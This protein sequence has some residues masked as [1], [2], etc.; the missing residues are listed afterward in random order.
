MGVNKNF[1]VKNG[2]EVDT[3]LILANAESNRVGIGTSLPTRLLHVN[4]A[5]GATHLSVSGI[6][7][8]QTLSLDGSIS[9]ANTYGK[10]NQIIIA[11]GIGGVSWKNLPE[12][13]VSESYVAAANQT[14]FV[15]AETVG[16]IDVY[17]NGV[18]L[19]TDNFVYT[20][21][22]QISLADGTFQGDIVEIIGYSAQTL[23][24]GAGGGLDGITVYQNGTIKGAIGLVTAIDFID[25]II[26]VNSTG[27]A[28]TV[29]G[30]GGG[31]IWKETAT[32]LSTITSV[33][34]GTTNA[35]SRLTVVG[36]GSFTEGL[37]VSGIT[38]LGFTTVGTSST[39]LSLYVDGGTTVS[40]VVTAG[41]FEGDGS[42]ITG[43][44]AS[45]VDTGWDIS[46]VG[47]GTTASVGIGTTNP[48]AQLQVGRAG[49]NLSSDNL[50]VYGGANITGDV[51]IGSSVRASFGTL[52]S[53]TFELSTIDVDASS[54]GLISIGG[55]AVRIIGD[56]YVDGTQNISNT[57]N[58]EVTDKVVG[59]ASTS[60]ANDIS[61]DGGG[62]ILY[63]DSNKEFLWD[64]GNNAW[65]SNVNIDLQSNRTYHVGGEPRLSYGQL[66]VPNADI[67]GIVTTGSLFS[68]G[69]I[70]SNGNITASTFFGSGN[71]LTG[72]VT[73]IVAGSNITISNSTG[74]VIINAIGVGTTGGGG[75]VGGASVTISDTPPADP[76]SGDLWY[77]S[78]IGRAFIW[79]VDA[80]TSQWVDLSPNGGTPSNSITVEN[81]GT[82]L[83]QAISTINFTG[84]VSISTSITGIATVGVNTEVI[85]TYTEVA[86]IATYAA[87]AGIATYS[88]TAGIAT[89]AAT[90]GI[91]TYAST[92][93]IAS[94][95]DV[96]GISSYTVLS[97]LSTYAA[98]SGIATYA[99]TAGVATVS[100]GLTG[101]PN[102]VV[103]ILTA[104]SFIGDG[105]GLTGVTAEGTGIVVKDSGSIVGTAGTIDFGD[106][107]SLSPVVSGV[108]TVTASGGGSGIST[109]AD[110]AG[111]STYSISAGIAT[112]SA[113]AGVSSALQTARN[114]GGVS[115]DGSADINL[116]GVNINGNQN[117]SGTAAGLSGIPNIEVGIVTATTYYG[118]A[119]N[120]VDGKWTLGAN[121]TT[122]FTFT[123]IGFTQTTNDPTLYLARGR[124]YEFVNN[125]GGSHPFRI[126]STANGSVGT[127]YNDG[128]TNNDAATGTIRFEVPFNAPNTLYYQ[129]TNHNDM[130]GSLVIYPTI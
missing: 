101:T 125:S 63:G 66:T 85:A 36:D 25:Q 20:P 18:K 126:Q 128:V 1:V 12:L 110:V 99:V 56:L 68:Y 34:I 45:A 122:D 124:V 57:I 130:G 43:I 93:G 53:L 115:F 32:G 70:Q 28:V 104:S 46:S 31:S 26:G 96:A 83:T 118:D 49:Y 11:D 61:S 65:T 120:V 73:S 123:G 105:S 98:L 95:S 94:Y 6:A 117:T 108:V 90:A 80:D 48:Q 3:D 67:S 41:Y 79:Y 47:I 8:V 109:Y 52:G 13:R 107:L 91:A 87:T 15:F 89:Y 119:S 27:Y 51:S 64:F 97:G 78:V 72:I 7:T 22:V 44:I 71:A 76:F 2:L 82:P 19:S 60:T 59:L 88:E 81:N 14:D 69:N 92:S 4:G 50:L 40:G 84:N 103:G 74:R 16:Y 24:V 121:G 111:I 75:S 33:G 39:T 112:Y 55:T 23:G 113:T 9:I 127:Q 10:A 17:I 58:L 29:Y 35:T 114:I 5:I 77:D 106:N 62:I 129:C 37:V 86:G 116:P 38:T 21:G 30:G 100:Q 42:R 102:L 54:S